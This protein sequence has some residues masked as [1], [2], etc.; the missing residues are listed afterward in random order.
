MQNNINAQSDLHPLVTLFQEAGNTLHANGSGFKTGHEPVHGSK[1][2]QCVKIDPEKAVWYCFSCQRG[3]D[4]VAAVMSLQGISRSAAIA[5]LKERFGIDYGAAELDAPVFAAPAAASV[6]PFP[7]EVLPTP[8]RRLV[9][10]GA[11][12]MHCPPDFIG[13]HLLTLAGAAIGASREIEVKRGWREG[14]RIFSGVVA[15]PGSKKSPALWLAATAYYRR[16]KQLTAEYKREKAKYNTELAQYEIDLAVWKK[17]AAKGAADAEEK[18]TPPEEPHLSQVYTTDSTTEALADVHEKNPRSLVYL[19][20]ELTGWAHAFNQYKTGGKGAD[21]QAWLSFWSGAPVLVNRKSRKDPIVLD[22]P[23]IS[24]TGCLPP[25]VLPDLSD[26]RGREDGFVHRILF[27]YPN[28]LPGAWTENEIDPATIDAAV[29]VFH[30]LWELQL[31]MREEEPVPKVCR[32]T[33][34]AKT[35]W[36]QWFNEHVREQAAEDFPKY[37]KGPWAKMEGYCVRLVLTL[38]LCRCA[39]RESQ[40]EEIDEESMAGAW[41]LIH[42]FKS[43]ARRVYARLRTTRG[44]ERAEHALAWIGKQATQQATARD[45]LRHHVAGLKTASE[46]RALLQDLVDRGYGTLTTQGK[47][48]IFSL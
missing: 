45:L 29:A 19:N 11:Q 8:F 42:Y 26:E 46:A 16:H 18:P 41:A 7:T 5:V 33:A 32:F 2:G 14:A 23:F 15:E 38:H 10:E 25:E 12:A 6:E 9:E 1:S 35:L 28:P 17:N 22:N 34:G 48:E 3:G 37:L 44:D 31:D 4:I 21:R 36:V 40:S 13:V 47:R 27:S 24:V 43:H 30:K 20:D 39:A